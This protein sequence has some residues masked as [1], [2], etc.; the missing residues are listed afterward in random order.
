MTRPFKAFVLVVVGS[1]LLAPAWAARERATSVSPERAW[2]HYDPRAERIDELSLHAVLAY[3]QARTGLDRPV[4]VRLSPRQRTAVETWIPGE[5]P[6]RVGIKKRLNLK[7]DFS[8]DSQPFGAARRTFDGGFVWTGSL[9]SDGA[10]AIR[11]K[12]AD[13]DLPEGYQLYVY[14]SAG[15]V[16]GPFSGRGPGDRSSFWS[17]TPPA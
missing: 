9:R 7:V 15:M 13:F 3:E 1:A 12:F 17:P 8:R 10:S 4:E 6:V 16:H 5:R 2:G 11:L 14:S